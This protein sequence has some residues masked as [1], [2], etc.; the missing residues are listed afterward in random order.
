MLLALSHHI[1]GTR[2]HFQCFRFMPGS[3]I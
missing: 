3:F 1:L 2:E